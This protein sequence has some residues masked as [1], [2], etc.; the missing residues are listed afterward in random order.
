MYEVS[1]AQQAYEA[2]EEFKAFWEAYEEW[3]LFHSSYSRV[4]TD[5]RRSVLIAAQEHMTGLLEK[6]R[7]TPEHK[8]AF[9]W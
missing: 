6:A 2:T 7:Q 3:E 8:A 4:P 9:G 1:L 5:R